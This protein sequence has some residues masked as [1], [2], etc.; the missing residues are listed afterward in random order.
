MRKVRIK[1]YLIDFI[2][3]FLVLTL[4]NLL[5]PKTEYLNTLEMEQN[6]IMEDYM[7][8][9]IN[10][11]NYVNNYGALYYESAIEQQ[12]NYLIYLLFMIIYFVI[13]PFFWKGRT[14][15]CYICKVQIERFDQGR[16]YMWQLL[17]RYSVV[18]GI[19]YVFLNNVLLILLPSKWYFPII[20]MIAIFQF[21]LALFSA[22]TVLI[23]SEKRGLHELISNTEITKIIN[24]SKRS[25]DL[26]P[27]KRKNKSRKKKK[28]GIANS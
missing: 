11:S 15:G 16:L 5:I 12:S 6:A 8:G 23:H 3:L 17:V 24:S 7:S 10:F 21:V 2:V 19:G 18:F 25:D 26:C 14:L 13:I 9:R 20:S 4:I 1:A 27:Q 22:G 28:K